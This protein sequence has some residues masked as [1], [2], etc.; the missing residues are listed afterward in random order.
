VNLP[1]AQV[2]YCGEGAAGKY[3]DNGRV[4]A[5]IVTT[6]ASLPNGTTS[7]SV[8]VKGA[9]RRTDSATGTLLNCSSTGAIEEFLSTSMRKRLGVGS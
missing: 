5:L 1:I 2:F 9:L 8:Q 3:V 7:A 6:L 4:T